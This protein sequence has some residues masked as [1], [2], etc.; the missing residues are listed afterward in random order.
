MKIS[1][2]IA[3][4]KHCQESYGDLPVVLSWDGP[5]TASDE[6]LFINYLGPAPDGRAELT[7]ANYPY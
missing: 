6:N 7:I 3:T 5:Q 2:L 4:L 1:E